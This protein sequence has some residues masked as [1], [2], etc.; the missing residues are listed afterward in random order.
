MLCRTIFVFHLD[1]CVHVNSVDPI[2]SILVLQFHLKLDMFLRCSRVG[3][4][5]DLVC[6]PQNRFACKCHSKQDIL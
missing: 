6:V 3:F 5:L 2:H 1:L 4:R